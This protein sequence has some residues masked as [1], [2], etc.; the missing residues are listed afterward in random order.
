MKK[1]T[2]MAIAITIAAV[3]GYFVGQKQT[4][5]PDAA[6]QPSERKVLY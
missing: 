2:L 5:Q 6:S 4:H 3:G 1:T